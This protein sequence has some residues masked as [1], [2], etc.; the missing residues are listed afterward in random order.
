MKKIVRYIFQKICS[1]DLIFSNYAKSDLTVFLYHDVSSNPAEFSQR[2]G[3]NVPPDI[4]KLQMKYI[5][6]NYNVISPD[7]LK[8]GIYDSPAALIT[9]DDGFPSYFEEAVPILASFG[10]P[11]LIFLNMAPINGDI[12]WSGLVTY[13]CDHSQAFRNH[14]IKSILRPLDNNAYLNCT[15]AIVRN[16]LATSDIDEIYLAARNFYGRFANLDHCM[17]MSTRVGEV[18]FGNHL[19]NHYNALLMNENELRENISLNYQCLNKFPNYI[20]FFSYPFGQPDTCYNN[21]T[22]RIVNDCGFSF[23][24]SAYNAPNK[25]RGKKFLNR[26]SLPSTAVTFE[27]LRSSILMPSILNRT[28]RR[29]KSGYY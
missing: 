11:S 12:F 24:F 29:R 13:L 17:N 20:D 28:I 8:S 6:Q 23:I 3:L 25:V 18:Y 10:F 19:Y 26:I 7:Q 4:F 22:D 1:S 14:L 5:E 15:P 16:F 27:N 21:A 9:F 2:Y